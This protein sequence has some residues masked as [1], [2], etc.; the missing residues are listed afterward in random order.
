MSDTRIMAR[1]DVRVG[2]AGQP[3]RRRPGTQAC[4]FIEREFRLELRR[5]SSRHP[6]RGP[7][8]LA[9]ASVNPCESHVAR[10]ES[11]DARH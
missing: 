6:W 2:F 3:P 10:P 11:V 1:E 4:D 8:W 7:A 5:G 9:F